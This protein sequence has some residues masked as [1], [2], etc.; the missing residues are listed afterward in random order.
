MTPSSTSPVRGRL[1]PP[2]VATV[3]LAAVGLLLNGDRLGVELSGG[4][5]LPVGGLGEVWTA[6]L[7]AWHPVAGGTASAAPPALAILGV[8]GAPFAPIGGAATLVAV[9]L[10]GQLPLAGLVAYA[11][12]RRWCPNPWPRAGVAA[13]Y[14]LLPAA[15]VSAPHGRLDV[16]V[17]HLLLPPLLAGFTAMLT[18][19]DVRSLS[20]SVLCAL[21]LAALAAFSPLVCALVLGAVLIGFV[22]LPAPVR[23]PLAGVPGVAIVVLLPLVLL[24]P[25]LPTLFTSPALFLHGIAGPARTQPG[26]VDLLG[27][28]PAGTALPLGL[29]LAA[30]ALIAALVR[31]TARVVAGLVV[32]ALGFGGVLLAR[33]IETTPVPGGAPAP[34]YTGAPL[35]LAGAG[36]LM[37]VLATVGVPSR[38]PVRL[39]VAGGLALVALLGIGG[40][41]TGGDGPVRADGGGLAPPLTAELARDGRGVLVLGTGG[42]PPRMAVGR[43]LAYGDDALVPVAGVPARLAGWQRDLLAGSGSV[44]VAAVTSAAA[45][46]IRFVVLPRGEDGGRLLAGAPNL[47]TAARPA[48]DGRAVLRL[49]TSAGPVTVVSPEQANRAVTGQ[50]PSGELM[51]GPAVAPVD[52]DLPGIRVRVSDGPAGR[53]LV[54]AAEHE[55]GWQATVNGDSVPIVPAWGHQVAVSVPTRQAEITVDFSGGARNVLLLVQVAAV[56]FALLTAI[57]GARARRTAGR[58]SCAATEARTPINT[59]DT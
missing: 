37:V 22:V 55:D 29:A 10:L 59:H 14:A 42:E 15:V 25:W 53:L 54:L 33:L 5:L 27:L 2:L 39:E 36:L 31:P 50:A 38:F 1:V 9:L 6:Y 12:I 16:V 28:D 26:V 47:V 11:A 49:T 24:L 7:D 32:L 58:R 35:V 18:R 57:P 43:E 52:V 34:G 17:V 13:S 41:V 3:V 21:G 19:A 46:G 51:G 20:T 48:R 40:G 4:A 45:A 56:L 8:L 23:R 44:A 30:A